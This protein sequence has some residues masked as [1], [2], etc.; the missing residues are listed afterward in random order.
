MTEFPGIYD[1]GE[2]EDKLNYTFKDKSLLKTALTHPSNNGSDNYERL[3]FLGDA[4]LELLISDKL[5]K[6]FPKFS[7][8]KLTKLRA[9]IVCSKSLAE[10]AVSVN[11]GSCLFLGK[12]EEITGG[13][14]K[15]SILENAVEALTGAI[16]LDGGF[17][18][19]KNAV[20]HL[21]D[22]TINEKINR[23]ASD[24]KTRLQE[25]IHKTSKLPISYKVSEKKGPPHKTIFTVELEVGDKKV[26]K[27]TGL[28]KKA[29]EQNA[30][31]KALASFDIWN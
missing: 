5:Y 8:G 21:F 30:A 28:S 16:Y 7:E 26:C 17:N 29:A 1:F 23:P 24:Y 6:Q 14:T 12:G 18:A 13:R 2:L 11:L 10:I 31:Q 4:V 19:A 27:A 20:N 15:T 25:K 3:E 9:N 22:K